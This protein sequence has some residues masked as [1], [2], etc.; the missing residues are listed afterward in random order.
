MVQ[1]RSTAAQGRQRSALAGFTAARG[2]GGKPVFGGHGGKETPFVLGM[3]VNRERAL[4]PAKP[5]VLVHDA[6]T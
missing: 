3:T 4:V 1:V 2:R 5:S 6:A